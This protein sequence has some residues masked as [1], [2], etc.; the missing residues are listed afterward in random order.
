MLDRLGALA[1]YLRS[2]KRSFKIPIHNRKSTTVSDQMAVNQAMANSFAMAQDTVNDNTSK[3]LSCD[4]TA[5]A[6]ALN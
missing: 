4:L 3:S 2:E 1:I 6:T 5:Q